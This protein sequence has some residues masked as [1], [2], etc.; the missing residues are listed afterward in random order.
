ML[1]TAQDKA[2]RRRAIE[3]YIGKEDIST[4]CW[5]CSKAEKTIVLEWT[6]LYK[7]WRHEQVAMVLYCQNL[8]FGQ[9]NKSERIHDAE[10]VKT[11]SDMKIQM[12][13]CV[14]RCLSVWYE[15]SQERRVE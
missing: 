4:A 3:K 12:D 11:L 1:I 13:K 6:M 15:N 14:E 8:G 9:E 10:K 7:N 2:I 5:L